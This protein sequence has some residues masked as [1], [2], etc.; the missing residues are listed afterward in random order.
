M[1]KELKKMENQQKANEQ[2]NQLSNALKSIDKMIE[3][4]YADAKDRLMNN[5]EVGFELIANSIFYFQ[6]IQ[7]VLQTVKV[8]FQTYVKTAQ[9]MD[10]IEG[11]RPVLKQTAAMMNSYPSFSK[12]NKDF[13]KFKKGL[14]RG[15]LNMK[16]MTSM[17]TTINPAMD[18][19]RSKEEFGA[20]KERLMLGSSRPM[21]D[22][23]TNADANTASSRV[24]QNEDFFNAINR[25]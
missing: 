20:L 12:N 16:A 24:A 1:S 17:M 2:L 25:D 23:N 11:I 4:F 6:D 14:M 18:T 10:T 19:M 7:K 13:M 21:M 3:E 8:Q 9:F 22:V 5:D 15:Q